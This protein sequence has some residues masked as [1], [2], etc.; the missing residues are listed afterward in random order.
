[1]R[2]GL[3]GKVTKI[4]EIDTKI[5]SELLR[6]AKISDRAL[7]RK[8]GVSQPTITRR[9][10][11]LEKEGKLSYKLIPELDKLGFDILA[12]TFAIYKRDTETYSRTGEKDYWDKL[13]EYVSRNPEI[14]FASSGEGLGMT[15]LAITVHKDFSSYVEF[16]KRLDEEWGKYFEKLETFFVSLKSDNALQ[17]F[18][19]ENILNSI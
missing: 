2:K 13:R 10:M 16:R 11:R 12:F 8:L 1:V 5:I 17:N 18:T 4:K 9:R 15:R 3:F 14:V 7:S 19:F 6:N